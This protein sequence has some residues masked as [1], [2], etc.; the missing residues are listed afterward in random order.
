MTGVSFAGATGGLLF[1]L[2]VTLSLMMIRAPGTTDVWTFRDWMG[3]VYQ[4]GLAAG[5]SKIVVGF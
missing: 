3:T 4:N 1:V 2:T 5:Y